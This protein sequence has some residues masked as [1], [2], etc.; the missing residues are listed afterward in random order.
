MSTYCPPLDK[1]MLNRT[2]GFQLPEGAKA[3]LQSLKSSVFWE[4]VEVATIRPTPLSMRE[5][6]SVDTSGDGYEL[7]PAKFEI[8]DDPDLW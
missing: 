6:T 4:H 3:A 7:T 1:A 5:V 8:V 2:M